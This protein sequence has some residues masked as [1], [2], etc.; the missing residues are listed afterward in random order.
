MLC[1][2]DINQ[3]QKVILRILSKGEW[4]SRGQ[5]N[6]LLTDSYDDVSFMTVNRD[7]SYLIDLNYIQKQG[8]GKATVYRISDG[9]SIVQ[10]IDP[11]EYFAQDINH[12]AIHDRFN[13]DIFS[14]LNIDILNE[15]EKDQL[16]LLNKQF[17][18]NYEKLSETIQKK[19]LERSAIELSWKSSALEGNTYSLLETETLIREG[20]AATGKKKEETI[21]VLNHKNALEYISQHKEEFINIRIGTIEHLHSILMQDLGISNNIRQTLV[22]ITGTNYKP[23]DNAYQIREALEQYCTLINSKENVFEKALLTFPLMG[24]IQPFEDGNKRTGR[25]LANALLI[26]H[27]AFPI[28]LRSLDINEYKDAMILF[29][30]VNN[31]SLIKKLFIQQCQFAVDNF[32]RPTI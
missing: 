4:L 19:E 30:E 31:I 20:I 29:Y 12:R 32:F 1:I 23:L 3:R 14:L 10:K 6:D 17:H 7:I 13:F 24:Y 15:D 26:S 21:M 18:Q 28:S 8:N 22:G 25:I 27:N 5:I 11:K 2:V 9:Y 16:N